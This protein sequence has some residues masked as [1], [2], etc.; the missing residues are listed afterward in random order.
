MTEKK[1]PPCPYSKEVQLRIAA[2]VI[3]KHLPEIESRAKKLFRD[4]TGFREKFV[5][6]VVTAIPGMIERGKPPFNECILKEDTKGVDFERYG[7]RIWGLINSRMR[8]DEATLCG[9]L[10][11]RKERQENEE[12]EHPGPLDGDIEQDDERR[13]FFEIAE[14][15]VD[16]LVALRLI[17]SIEGEAW[18]LR[19]LD[20]LKY[21]EIAQ[22]IGKS[23]QRAEVYV[24]KVQG[25]LER[26]D[27]QKQ[28]QDYLNLDARP[29]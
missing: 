12:N 3:K 5:S 25:L 26:E 29:P 7:G 8:K 24:K 19:V 23:L 18:L 1:H 15:A 13:A 16:A 6:M 11:T 20:G 22:E 14:D 17:R 28:I 27:V 2:R 4:D 21:R 10:K 9:Q